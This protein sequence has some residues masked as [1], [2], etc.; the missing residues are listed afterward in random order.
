M[1]FLK[2]LLIYDAVMMIIVIPILL[3]IPAVSLS[4]TVDSGTEAAF[5]VTKD[6]F[7]DNKINSSLWKSYTV[8][9]GPTVA[10]RNKRLEITFPA[11]SSGDLFGAGYTT[12]CT[13]TGDFDI[14]VDYSLLTWPKENGVR[15]GMGW[16]S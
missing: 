8:G 12:V 13:L 2:R 6:D 3:F 16:S 11:N 5:S 10:E 14:Q 15:V 9:S 4:Q 7:N 1:A